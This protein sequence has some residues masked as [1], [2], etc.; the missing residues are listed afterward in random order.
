MRSS[1]T[2]FPSLFVDPYG[3]ISN[4]RLPTWAGEPL[5]YTYRIISI[6]KPQTMDTSREKQLDG[7][8][9]YHQLND[10]FQSGAREVRL[11]FRTPRGLQT[12][13]FPLR[14]I[15]FLEI[16]FF[17]GI[18]LLIAWLVLWSGIFVLLVSQ[19]RAGGRAYAF[20]AWGA[21]LFFSCFFDYHT[22]AFLA[23]LFSLSTVWLSLG[24]VWL[25][26]AFPDPPTR[27]G[28]A[29]LAAKFATIIGVGAAFWLLVA[30]SLGQDAYLIR[31]SAPYAVV[32]G[33][34]ILAGSVWIRLRKSQA[35]SRAELLSAQWGL[36]LVPLLIALVVFFELSIGIA[37]SDLAF[38]FVAPVLPLALGYALIRNNILK[39][40]DVLKH[41]MLAVPV[42]LLSLALAL[43]AALVLYG[44]AQASHSALLVPLAA[45]V[46]LFVLFFTAGKQALARAFFS[47]TAQFRPSIEHL[48]DQL[49]DARGRD[50]VQEAIERVVRLWLPAGSP[51]VLRAEQLAIIDELP[52]NALARLSAGERLWTK[53][54][55]WERRLL[56][57][58]RS[59]QELRGVLLLA[60]KQD[61]ALYTS[62]DIALLDTI[63]SLGAVALHNAEVVEEVESLRRIEVE[64]TRGEKRLALGTLGAE[65]SHEIA[66]PLN[67]FKYL[68]KQG[69]K[70]R[71][72]DAQD[73]EIGQE[74]VA[75]LERM[76]STL[77][78]L[79]SPPPR[80][81]PV[82]LGGP[83]QRALG[84]LQEVVKER[85]LRV[86][87][88]VAP[89]LVVLGDP[90]P[91]LQL[92]ANLLRNAAQATEDGGEIGVRAFKEQA[93]VVVEVW[94]SGPGIPPELA[95]HIFDPWV[96]TREGGSGLGLAITQR[97]VHSFGGQI[98]FRRE[99]KRT[100]FTAQLPARGT[101]PR[102]F[103][104][105]EGA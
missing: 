14:T 84:L 101:I 75:R 25:G 23:P 88:D 60:P 74:E 12:Q 78:K 34:L 4:S 47:A 93:H 77:R 37:L 1:N 15:G 85:R 95:A 42:L 5:P 44:V 104:R 76:L 67:F 99:D 94:D 55:T 65:L 16:G 54:T 31:L 41:W 52:T 22:E 43:L 38:P 11:G 27:P 103:D 30:P 26:Y 3:F 83:L 36:A 21:F 9:I 72:L 7:Q 87:V 68:L 46:V 45:G 40:D 28:V 100:Y 73:A 64:A 53:V 61:A 80:T 79:K 62:E 82:N 19:R 18:Y 89:D 48:S 35:R 8:E 10:L 92:F 70:G 33:M 96:T 58:M 32:A 63:G 17:F 66:Y 90:D 59:Q 29:F 91:L 97:I 20:W 56:I 24:F 102:S 51:Q 81:E 13:V 86:S 98:T 57:P 50:A 105:S 71:P 6:S 69:S 49:S 39:M 2:S